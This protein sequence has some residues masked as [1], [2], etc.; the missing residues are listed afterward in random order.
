M[1]QIFSFFYLIFIVPY[2][3]I[4][5]TQI[6]KNIII[7]KIF[8]Y[9][10]YNIELHYLVIISIIFISL[11]PI[12]HNRYLFHLIPILPIAIKKKNTFITRLN[13]YNK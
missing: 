1:Y 12:I 13:Q 7:G 2:F 5:G 6:I 3:F 11:N 8:K 9:K 4:L 10:Y